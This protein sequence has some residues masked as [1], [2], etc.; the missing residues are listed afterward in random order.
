M[1]N[2]CVNFNRMVMSFVKLIRKNEK[3]EV[4]DWMGVWDNETKPDWKIKL[5]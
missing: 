4:L 5:K 1:V 3:E 2:R